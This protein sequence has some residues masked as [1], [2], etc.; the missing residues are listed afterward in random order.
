MWIHKN[1]CNISSDVFLILLLA[2]FISSKSRFVWLSFS[3]SMRVRDRVV[4]LLVLGKKVVFGI[5]ITLKTFQ[6]KPFVN[7]PVSS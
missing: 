4:K 6:L 5:N 2:C 3:S 1:V 7:F